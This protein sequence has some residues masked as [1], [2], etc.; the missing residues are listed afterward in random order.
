MRDWAKTKVHFLGIGGSGMSG[1]ARI[2]IARG[3]QVSGSDIQDSPSLAGLRSIGATVLIGHKASNLGNVDFVVRSS[4]IAHDNVEISEAR[5]R[6]ST[7]LNS[8]HEW[9]SR[10]PSS[11]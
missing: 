3:A 9:I 10:M 6:K 5:D 8:S 2:M 7:R 1:I 11:A 4:A